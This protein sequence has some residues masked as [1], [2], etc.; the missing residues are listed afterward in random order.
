MKIDMTNIPYLDEIKDW[1]QESSK[2]KRNKLCGQFKID[3]DFA[4]RFAKKYEEQMT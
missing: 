4:Y 2:S 1:I 3:N